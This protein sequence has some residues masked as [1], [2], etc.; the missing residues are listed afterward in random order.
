MYGLEPM[1]TGYL[2]MKDRLGFG[3]KYYLTEEIIQI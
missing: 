1:E 2:N 3:K